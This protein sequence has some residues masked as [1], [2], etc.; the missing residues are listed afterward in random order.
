MSNITFEGLNDYLSG[1]LS[2]FGKYVIK[3]TTPK[4]TCTDG[5]TLSVQTGKTL[6]CSPREDTGPWFQVEVGFP[7]IAPPETWAEYFDGD[8]ASDDRTSSVYGYIPID[9]VIEFINDHGG[10]ELSAKEKQS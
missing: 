10:A 7:S 5:V 1:R 3:G 4:I 6:Y 2:T 8:W 9:L